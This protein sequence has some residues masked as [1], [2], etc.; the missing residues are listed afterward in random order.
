MLS[1]VT[2]KVHIL[3]DSVSCRI[4]AGEVVERPASVVKELIDNSLDAGSTLITVEVE[5]GG[6]RVIRVMD[7][8]AGMTRMDAQL[9]CQRFATSKLRSEEDLLTLLTMGFRGEAL[10]SIAS[11]SRFFLKTVSPESPLGT[12][13]QS[14][15]GVAWEVQDYTGHLGTQVEVRD[16]FFNTP[17]RLKFLKTV[18]TEFSKICYVVQQA[19]SVHPG[20]HFRL[21]HQNHMVL[22]YPAVSSLQDRLLQIYGPD[23]LERF[24]PVT[25]NAGSFQLTGF[26]VSPHHARTSRAPQEIFVNGRPIKNSTISHAMHEAYGSFLSKGKHPQFIVFI[27][28]DPQSIDI[29]VHP[30]KREIRFSHP[31][32]IHSGVLRGIKSLFF[33]PPSPD[34]ISDEHKEKPSAAAPHSARPT[35]GSLTVAPAPFQHVSEFPGGGTNRHSPLSLFVQEPPSVYT[36]KEQPCEVYPLGQ[37]HHT[38]LLGQIDQDLFIV[39]QHTAHERV[40]FERLLRSWKKKEILQQSL[41][42]PEPVELLPHQGELLE[43]WLPF[44]A[45]AGLEV[46]RFGNTSYVVR[47]IP[48]MLGNIS[49]GSLVLELLDE[50]SEWQSTDALDNTIKPILA[51]MACQ[52][53]VQAGRPMTQAEITILLQD[54]AQENFPMTCP[55]GRRVAIRHSLGELHTIFARP[56]K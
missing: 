1:T 51:T 2:G 56:L 43:E 14:M 55:H 42:I 37:I 24:L 28:L 52:S 32:F 54:W 19:A 46:E 39:D 49:I 7:N 40:R 25:Y 31:E 48:A 9:A 44:L 3:P 17:G 30:T 50:L 53:A 21:R 33:T 8:G 15:G 11:V 10:P 18:P 16:L 26:T 20:I 27:H 12:Q 22:E 6:R 41:L 45:Q 5:E 36:R 23:F 35:S 4:A 13:T 47:A 34:I 29:N 38:Y